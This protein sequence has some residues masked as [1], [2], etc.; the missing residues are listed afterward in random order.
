MGPILAKMRECFVTAAREAYKLDAAVARHFSRLGTSQT[1][2]Q[3]LNPAFSEC[4]V[5]Q[6]LM[7]LKQA[8]ENNENRQNQRGNNQQ[9][10]VRRKMLYCN[11]CQNGWPL[12]RGQVRP[13]TEGENGGPPFRCPI[14]SF[15]VVKIERGD[16]YDGNGYHVCPKCFSEPPPDL[17]GAQVGGSDFRCFSCLH[18]TCSLA[19]GIQG[20]DTEAF[21]C[22]F[23]DATRAAGKAT[24]RKNARGF[25]LS[26]SNYSA[27]TRCSYTIWLPKESR[28]VTVAEGDENICP[29]CTRQNH[30]VRKIKFD[31]KPNSVPPHLGQGCTVCILCDVDFRREM[32][33]SLPQRNQ[34]MTNPRRRVVGR[35][36]ARVAAAEQPRAARNA[37]ATPGNTCYRCGQPGHFA[38]ACPTTQQ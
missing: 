7:A 14:C 31:W 34:V 20:G 26:C 30:V 21:P 22:S 10:Q 15:Q 12:P 29:N 3:V 16:G 37:N 4:G 11:T 25:V 32:E 19:G 1:G 35:G 9:N 38:N 13:K 33:I 2:S 36:G 23:C 18:A 27:Q 17:G 6:N 28:T 5:C 8:G 24:L